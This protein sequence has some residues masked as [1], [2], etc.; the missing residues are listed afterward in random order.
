[1]PL[2]K[3]PRI[4]VHY[5]ASASATAIDFAKYHSNKGVLSKALIPKQPI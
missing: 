3:R 1:M 2:K 5:S 4:V